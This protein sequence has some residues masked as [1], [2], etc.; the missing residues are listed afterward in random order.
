VQSRDSWDRAGCAVDGHHSSSDAVPDRGGSTIPGGSHALLSSGDDFSCGRG[1]RRGHFTKS[2]DRENEEGAVFCV[3][4]QWSDHA[5]D[6]AGWIGLCARDYEHGLDAAA[7]SF[8]D[9]S[10]TRHIFTHGRT[11]RGGVGLCDGWAGGPAAG[12]TDPESFQHV[13]DIIGLDDPYGSLISNIPGEEFKK[14]G[15]GIGD[16]IVVQVDKKPFTVPYAKTFMDV[17]VG[18][19]LLYIDSRGRIGLALNQRNFSQVNKITPPG[20]IFIPRKG[21][22]IKK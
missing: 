10:W 22:A 5:G 13:G 16:K 15:Y 7:A 20:K 6:R 8:F 3:A 21:A 14:L 11:S 9:V 18:E 19:P 17:Q 2:R 1:S 4:R 12:T